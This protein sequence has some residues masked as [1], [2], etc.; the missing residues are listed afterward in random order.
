MAEILN[1]DIA[2]RLEDVV[3][4]L[5]EQGANP[6]RVRAYHRAAT[7]RRWLGRPVTEMLQQE[8]VEGLRKLLGLGESLTRLIHD[9][10]V[11]GRLSR[12]DRLRGEM[13]PVLRFASVPGIGTMLAEHLHCDLGIATLEELKA[14]VHDGRLAEIA[15]IGEKKLAGVIDS[16]A[17]RLGRV[18]VPVR[19]PATDAS[20]VEERLDV[21]HE[22]CEQ[23]ALG[24]RRRIAPRRFNPSGEVWLPV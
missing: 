22:Y 2:R 8:G 19:L 6:Y 23:A 12:L 21:D 18:R 7:T 16:L 10:V 13:D 9:L 20:A 14:A 3:R 5:K 1:V 24:T 11:T 15:G 17:T 4:L